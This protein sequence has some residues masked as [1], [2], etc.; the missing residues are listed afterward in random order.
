MDHKKILEILDLIELCRFFLIYFQ[1][2]KE[3]HAVNI[4]FVRL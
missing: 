4:L 3:I 1:K 2:F